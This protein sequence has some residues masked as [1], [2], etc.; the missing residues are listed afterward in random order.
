M[1]EEEATEVPL[2]PNRAMALGWTRLG[3]RFTGERRPALS[4]TPRTRGM[5]ASL[6]RGK[7][8]LKKSKGFWASP[9]KVS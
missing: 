3:S 5:D 8:P 2:R 7:M 6:Q 9:K 4:A 1:V